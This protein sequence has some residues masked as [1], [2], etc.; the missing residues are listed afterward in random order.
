MGG[1]ELAKASGLGRRHNFKDKTK[2]ESSSPVLCRIFS[3][4][5]SSFWQHTHHPASRRWAEMDFP[6]PQ[7]QENL[8][9]S[10]YLHHPCSAQVPWVFA[11]MATMPNTGNNWWRG[12]DMEK[13]NT[14]AFCTP[15]RCQNLPVQTSSSLSKVLSQQN[16]LFIYIYF[17]PSTISTPTRS[18]TPPSPTPK[19]SWMQ[20][21]KRGDAG[22][23]SVS[24]LLLAR[25][26][27]WGGQAGASSWWA[28]GQS[29]TYLNTAAL[30]SRLSYV[31]QSCSCVNKP[32]TAL[33]TVFFKTL[34]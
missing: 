30:H 32:L 10:S 28:Q 6:S 34:Q 25:G 12:K 17:S 31:L 22:R 33:A 15:H 1:W 24:Y 20:G 5:F 27:Q 7:S 3:C 9:L 8:F 14:S 21:R 16:C 11:V 23:L 19:S 26:D 2:A 4:I 29:N 13:Q 18:L